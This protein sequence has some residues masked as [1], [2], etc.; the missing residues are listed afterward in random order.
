VATDG[1]EEAE[2]AAIAAEIAKGT[3]PDLHIGYVSQLGAEVALN[4][5]SS[6]SAGRAS[7]R[8]APFTE[9]PPSVSLP[10]ILLPFVLSN[11]IF[12]AG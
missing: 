11:E 8:F 2:L 7:G 1:S 12:G 4:P 6:I 5:A 9:T 3:D 10:A